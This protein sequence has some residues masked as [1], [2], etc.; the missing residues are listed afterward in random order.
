MVESHVRSHADWGAAKAGEEGRKEGRRGGDA[1][2]DDQD[3]T[4]THRSSVCM[5][6]NMRQATGRA[7][8]RTS[9]AERANAS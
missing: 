3:A 5:G 7:D 1:A 6:M 9:E 2:G 8:E 4:Q